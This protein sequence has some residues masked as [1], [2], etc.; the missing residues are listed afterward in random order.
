MKKNVAFIA[1]HGHTAARDYAEEVCDNAYYMGIPKWVSN[2][3]LR[4]IVI[5]FRAFVY[6]FLI[7]KHNIYLAHGSP[8]L[9]CVITKRKI[10]GE[11]CKI[12]MRVNDSMFSNFDIKGVKKRFLRFLYKHIDGAIAISQMIKSDV[13]KELPGL[14]TEI[15]YCKVRDDK[16]FDI[17]PNFKK[18][19]IMCLGIAP[20]YRKGTDIQID[21]FKKFIPKIPMYIMGNTNY[22]FNKDYINDPNLY[23][24]GKDDPKKYLN[25]CLFLLHPARFDAGGNAVI[26]AMAAGLI[27]VVSYMTGNSDIVKNIDKSLVIE[28]FDSYDYYN[29]IKELYNK[30]TE[31]LK[32][33]SNKCKLEAYKYSK[34]NMKGKFKEAFNNVI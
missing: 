24:T 18:K 7:P 17:K 12:I 4:L 1:A 33:L 13:Q 32:I 8:G 15:V 31:D 20:N 26:E 10:L 3:T 9:V 21:V 2:T 28:T 30:S 29:K 27:P 14:P 19:S 22:L 6:A 23:F 34:K 5:Y 11:K 16:F 25:E